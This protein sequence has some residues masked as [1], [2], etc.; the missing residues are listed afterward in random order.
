MSYAVSCIRMATQD[1]RNYQ[2][3]MKNTPCKAEWSK[4]EK[5]NHVCATAVRIYLKMS[6]DFYGSPDEKIIIVDMGN[7]EVRPYTISP[8]GILRV[9]LSE[10]ENS[11]NQKTLRINLGDLN[12][13][14]ADDVLYG[15]E[16][17]RTVEHRIIFSLRL[18]RRLVRATELMK[19]DYRISLCSDSY[20]RKFKVYPFK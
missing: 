3:L 20:I 15:E 11:K 4:K 19:G 13:P 6:E 5:T 17:L 10:Y 2:W 18:Y 16:H 8:D 7:K 9:F 1:F 12:T 14:L